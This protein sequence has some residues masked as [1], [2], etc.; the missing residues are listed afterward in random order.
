MDHRTTLSA[1][2]DSYLAD[3]RRRGL[4][5]ATLRYYGQAIDAL[6][7][8][9]PRTLEEVTL[10]A[11]RDFL[12]ASATRSPAT[13]RGY[14][15]ALRTFTR[16]LA[17]EGAVPADPLARLRGPRVDEALREVPTDDEL[18]RILR[19]VA[20]G[21]RLVVALLLGTGLR[22]SEACALDCRDVER[23]SIAVRHPKGRRA[24]LLPLDPATEAIVRSCLR[25]AARGP[26]EPLLLSRAGDRVTPNAVRQLLRDA[27]ARAGL[28]I[29]V[30]PH[31]L[32]HWHARDLAAHGTETRLLAARMGWRPAGLVGR[33]APVSEHELV[34]DVSRYAP[35]ARL[36]EA[37][38]L[39]RLLPLR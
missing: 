31:V 39:R 7:G 11:G 4:R 12:D 20:P 37:P 28:A 14:V 8:T 13:L 18:A 24:R 22:T 1:A 32:R 38:E 6:G 9:G 30:S 16:W 29:P 3:C 19:A 36:A 15:R 2:R 27:A 25:V 26:R 10:A 33:Y 5:P 23:G 17:D 34:A 21:R 35:L